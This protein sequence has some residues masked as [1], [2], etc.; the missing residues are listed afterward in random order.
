MATPVKPIG[1]VNGDLSALG[2]GALDPIVLPTTVVRTDGSTPFVAPQAGEDPVDAADL[3]TKQWV[4]SNAGAFVWQAP[5]VSSTVTAQPAHSA[6][7]RYILSLAH[8]G[9]QWAGASVDQ[10]ANDDGVTWTFTTPDQGTV[11]R[12]LDLN[13]FVRYKTGTGWSD[14]STEIA[15]NSGTGLQG[16]TTNQYYH[17]TAA[18]YSA[19]AGS[20]TQHYAYLAPLNSAG[21]PSFRAFDTSDILT[22]ILSPAHGGFGVSTAAVTGYSKWSGG[23]AS[24]VA[25]ISWDDLTSV[26][27]T[28]DPSAHASSHAAA[29]S[30]PLTLDATQLTTG[31]VQLARGG[32]GTTGVGLTAK[33]FFASPT[34]S[35]GSA[36]YRALIPDDIAGAS[37]ANQLIRRN[38]A[39]TANEWADMSTVFTVIT[40]QVATTGYLAG[41]GALSSDLTL[42]WS[43]IDVEDNGVVAG[44]RP[45]INFTGT[46]VTVTDNPG[47]T[48]VD[49]DIVTG[50]VSMDPIVAAIVF[51]S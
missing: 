11:V 4:E 5:V 24:F 46:G 31:V 27:S 32:T 21:V 40:R 35:S 19:Y 42:S 45:I 6:G 18:Q 17:L 28:F 49:V 20:Q 3:T 38:T 22:G 15:H 9:A 34:A 2:A 23:V 12:V 47:S 1:L 7:A 10:I 51:G 30:D 14:I 37:A 25:G 43:G 36:S 16:G 26:P 33:Y 8:T 13:T 44:R 48:R 29:G 39:N 50:A 41:G